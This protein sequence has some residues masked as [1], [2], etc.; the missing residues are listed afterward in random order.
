MADRQWYTGRDGR[1]EGPFSDERIRELI[2]SGAVRGDTL[3]W[4]DGMANWARAADV[5]GLMPAGAPLTPG[6]TGRTGPLSANIGVWA[7]FWRWIVFYLSVIFIIPLPWIAPIFIRW[8]V[9][10]ISVPGTRGV[11]FAGKPGDIWWVFVLYAL[12]S[13]LPYFVVGSITPE[14]AESAAH[15]MRLF[16]YVFLFLLLVSLF[17]G[18]LIIRWVFANIVWEKQDTYLR[19]TGGYGP[20]LGWSVLYAISSLAIIAPA[21]VATAC[22][23]W[24]CRHVEG[25]SRELIFTGSGWGLLWRAFLAVIASIFIIPIPWMMRWLT[26]WLVSQLALVERGRA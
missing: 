2:A 6:H 8:F 4:S 11:S 17:L 25:S 5:P 10:R 23:R 12:C 3:V 19:F 16:P 14:N 9:E 20:L 22:A 21:W 26:C 18:L 1:Q 24:M 7:L 13:I 15:A